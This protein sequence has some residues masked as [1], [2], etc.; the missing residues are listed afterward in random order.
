MVEDLYGDLRTPIPPIAGKADPTQVENFV[1]ELEEEDCDHDPRGAAPMYAQV[2]DSKEMQ[3]H[4]ASELGPSISGYTPSPW[5]NRFGT[6]PQLSEIVGC[7]FCGEQGFQL[8]SRMD[9]ALDGWET[10]QNHRL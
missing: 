7:E 6:S 4:T 2:Y 5:R 3:E 8:R 9:G 1:C 10:F